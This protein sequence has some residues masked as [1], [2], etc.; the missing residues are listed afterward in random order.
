MN[1]FSSKYLYQPKKKNMIIGCIYRH[2]SSTLSIQD[3][4]SDIMEPMLEKISL[5]NKMCSLLGDFNIN[6]L[7]AGFS[8]DISLFYNTLTSHFFAPHIL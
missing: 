4:N 2:P 5:E 7:N 1:L 3:F 8:D 6:L